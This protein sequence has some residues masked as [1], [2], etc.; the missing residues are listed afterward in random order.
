[1]VVVQLDN[2]PLAMLD[3]NFYTLIR[4][5]PCKSVWIR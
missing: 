3:F 4:Y 1:M 5:R 2:N